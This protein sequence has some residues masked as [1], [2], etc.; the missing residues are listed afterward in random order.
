MA[1]CK[2]SYVEDKLLKPW[3]KKPGKWLLYIQLLVGIKM[4]HLGILSN[5]KL[6]LC[7]C[8][9]YFWAK[10]VLDIK[11]NY[12]N[13]YLHSLTHTFKSALKPLYIFIKRTGYRSCWICWRHIRYEESCENYK[14]LL[15]T[16][17]WVFNVAFGFHHC[18][19]CYDI[20]LCILTIKEISYWKAQKFCALHNEQNYRKR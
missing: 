9:P 3:Y 17:Q 20:T 7:L 4:C 13:S 15:I 5:V 14:N 12:S 2:S 19:S 8:P 18:L 11:R 1:V 16:E 6:K 10:T